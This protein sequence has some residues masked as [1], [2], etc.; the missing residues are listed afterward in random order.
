VVDVGFGETVSASPAPTQA[1]RSASERTIMV[2]VCVDLEQLCT[3]SPKDGAA[4]LSP[5]PIDHLVRTELLSNS[6]QN[7][8]YIVKN[9]NAYVEVGA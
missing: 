6:H 7:S 8:H 4:P 3:V 9:D 5:S 2:A 1:S